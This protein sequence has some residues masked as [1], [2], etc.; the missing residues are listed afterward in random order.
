M[1]TKIFTVAVVLFASI[2]VNGQKL[3]KIIQPEGTLTSQ[4]DDGDVKKLTDG[5][6]NTKWGVRQT[7]LWFQYEA[8][9][10]V[11][12]NRYMIAS[13][14]DV[15]ARDPKEWVLKASQDGNT[16]VDLDIQKNQTFPDRLTERTFKL[17]NKI[18]YK[19]YRLDILSNAGHPMT[20]LSEWSLLNSK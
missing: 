17:E 18:A 19:Y 16:W 8:P 2:V 3:T 4:Y 12:V 20:Q 10:A 11:V 9:A 7:A 5:N 6:V 1:K 15:P 13:A 14:N